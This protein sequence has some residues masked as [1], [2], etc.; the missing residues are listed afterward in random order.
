M[1][2]IFQS[3]GGKLEHKAFSTFSRILTLMQR[4]TQQNPKKV[5]AVGQ[6]QPPQSHNSGDRHMPNPVVL[7]VCEAA[8][9]IFNSKE[10]L[11]WL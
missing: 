10:V 6:M 1:V 3:W 11:T 9:A 2:A 5:F 8:V 4:K 7:G